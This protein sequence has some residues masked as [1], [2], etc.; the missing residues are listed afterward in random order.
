[1]VLAMGGKR[2]GKKT[3]PLRS[4][5][6]ERKKEM[7]RVYMPLERKRRKKPGGEGWGNVG[8]F[9]KREDLPSSI[10]GMPPNAFVG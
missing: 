1:M 7:K 4:N 6:C 2:G 8:S 5:R 9:L 10:G 3:V